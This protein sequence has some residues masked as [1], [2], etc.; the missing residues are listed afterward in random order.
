[1]RKRELMRGLSAALA[2][3][4]AMANMPLSVQAASTRLSVSKAVLSKGDKLDIDVLGAK[5]KKGMYTV[6]NKKVANITRG[7]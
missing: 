4:M 3:A 5:E 1:M 7:G 6:K 2:V